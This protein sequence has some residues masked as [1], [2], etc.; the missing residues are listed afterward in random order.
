MPSAMIGVRSVLVIGATAFPPAKL[1][2]I[3][4]GLANQTV[5]LAKIEDTRLAL[6]ELYRRHGYLL[7]T[8]SVGVSAQGDVRFV[9]T[10]GRIA[11]VKL[12]ND[13]G[14]A[15]TIVL[16]FLNHLTEE[17][18]IREATLEH[19]L[20]LAQQVPG[21]QLEAVLQADSDDPGALTLV[22]NVS[23]Q[24]INLLFTGNDRGFKATG[25]AEGLFVGDINS[26]TSLGDQTELSLFH[27]SGGTDNFGQIA[28][29][30][31]L[32]GDGLRLRVYGGAGRANPGG[33]LRST[34]Y[35]SEIQV[36]GGELSYPILLRRN[37]SLTLTGKLD[38]SDNT[39]LIQHAQTAFDSLRSAR[40][41]AQYA[42][43]D[44]VL[45]A[46]R[47]AVNVL[48]VNLSKGIPYFGA[49]PDG[50]VAEAGR[51]GE[52]VDYWKFSG[53]LTRTQNLFS[54]FPDANVALR[55]AVGGQYTTQ[56]LPAEEEFYLGGPQYTRGFYS[57]QVT[58]DSG[59]YATAELQLNTGVN[60]DLFNRPVD[61]GAQFYGFY[62]WGET[63]PNLKTDLR[64]KLQSAGGGVRLGLTRFVEI[65]GEA[66]KRLTTN[67]NPLSRTTLPVSETVFYWGVTVR[68]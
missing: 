61:L 28:E 68:Y 40:L 24:N 64:H 32:G 7:S 39:I 51:A 38:G 9:V 43:Q 49:S 36:F 15:G 31:F 35:R 48:D 33:A 60:F 3:T 42:L 53:A 67:L 20:L 55:T 26:L 27:T 5:P 59:V 29:S 37:Q 13:I 41:L 1:A 57:G 17:R 10:E 2:K 12:S 65:D 46:N 4:A 30:F 22:A 45:G 34:L 25:P 11:A 63:F 14:P 44:L 18:P 66:V 8:V 6:V 47:S 16:R 23:K 58:G 52:R 21:V 54:P 50:R 56:I 19:W 62:D